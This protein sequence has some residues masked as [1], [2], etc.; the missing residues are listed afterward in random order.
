MCAVNSPSERLFKDV[1]EPN[2]QSSMSIN[3]E[4]IAQTRKE[5]K[6]TSNILQSVIF[7]S[8]RRFAQPENRRFFPKFNHSKKETPVMQFRLMNHNLERKL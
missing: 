5:R 6:R 7:K 8:G 4:S 2:S 1:F 3:L